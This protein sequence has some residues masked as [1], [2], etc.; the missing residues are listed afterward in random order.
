MNLRGQVALISDGEAESGRAIARKLLTAGSR[1][2]INVAPTADLDS[3]KAA[4]GPADKER[5]EV[6][7]TQYG[8][9]HTADVEDLWKEVLTH[10]RRVDVLVHNS[11]L[12]QPVSVEDCDPQRY[13]ELMDVNVKSAFLL[14]QAF[15][16][17]AETHS[18]RIIYVSTIHDQKPTGSSFVYSVAKGAL[19]MLAREA[20]LELGRRGVSVNV[21]EMGPVE[22]DDLRFASSLSDVYTAYRF[23]VPSAVL[24]TY[25]DLAHL[26]WFLALP[27]SR[28]LNGASIRLDGGFH[29]HYMNHKMKRE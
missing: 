28:F 8:L 19:A 1:V 21:I 22:G 9:S 6:L 27:E 13:Q 20:A 23:K 14:T 4:F 15:G 7:W 16:R 12:V 25:A 2:V 26:V 24:G 18:G 11:Q 29:L 10:W 17:Q 5:G 3:L